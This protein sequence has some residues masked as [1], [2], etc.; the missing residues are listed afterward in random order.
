M[1]RVAACFT[2]VLI[3]VLSFSNFSSANYFPD[4]GPDLPR[5]YIKSDGSVEPTSAL[6]QKIG[7][8]YELTGDIAGY[9]IEIQCDNVVLDGA[10]FSIQGDANRVK[11]YDDGNNGVIITNRHN[12]NI[13][14]VNFEQ[15]DTGVRV[16]ASSEINIFNNN[17]SNGLYRGVVVTNSSFV[18]I[19]SNVFT[20]VGFNW[21]CI[22]LFAS[23]NTVENNLIIGNIRALRVEGES[24]IISGNRIE[25]VLPIMMN[26]ASFNTV[27]G[28][29]LTG[30]APSTSMPDRNYTGNEGISLFLS[31][32][33]LIYGNNI[34]GFINNAVRFIFSSENNT[35]FGNC[36][37]NTGFVVVI[38][39]GAINNSFYGNNFE[40]D[41][42]NVSISE[43]HTT[44]WDNGTIGNY[45]ENYQG[46]DNNGDGIGDT[47]YQLNGYIWDQK[48][49]GFVSVS[50]GQDNYPIMTPYALE[51]E[52]VEPTASVLPTVLPVLCLAIAA[53]A[54][55]V[56]YF[57]K[58]NC[59]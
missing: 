16:F 46:I 48:V 18:H 51:Q 27:S 28:N 11:G 33:N 52:T 35:V 4:P 56:V 14:S 31:S 36:M 26:Y 59:K 41:S 19:K 9:T 43:V 20:D 22:N 24:N 23:Q 15:G 2:I 34:T 8:T 58:H 53:V 3:A 1:K 6:I 54:G 39:E 57:K 44:F 12:V 50:A 37:V 38:Q 40:A 25:S 17:F 47:P 7:G 29:T 10:G 5:I 13:T 30:P 49:D 21:S 32:N 45:W 55:L 42:C